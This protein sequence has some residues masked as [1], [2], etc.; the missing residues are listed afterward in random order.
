MSPLAPVVPLPLAVLPAREVFDVTGPLPT[1]TTVLE[2]SAGTGKTYTIAALAVRFVAEG[3]ATLPELMLVTFGREATRELRDRVRERFVEVADGLADPAAARARDDRVLALLA[4]GPDA[5]VIVRRRRLTHA[6]AHFDA[7]TIATTHQ[8]CSRML[9]GLGIVGD[10]DPG[11]EFTEDVD[12]LVT[13]VVDDFYVRKYAD[14]RA[15]RPDFGRAEALAI[16]RR[17]VGDPEARLTPEPGARP[18]TGGEGTA[19]VRRAFAAAVRAE[20]EHRKRARRLYTYD[21]MLTRL[22][23][24]LRHPT[25]GAAACARLRARYRVVLVDEFQDTDPL[26]WAI[27]RAAFH[28]DTSSGTCSLTFIGDPKQAIYAFRGADVVS[29][30]DAADH[31]GTH[32]TLDVNWRSD[33]RLVEALD[34]LLGGAALGDEKIVVGSVRARHQDARLAGAPVDA[35]LRLRVVPRAGLPATER[36]LP[37][38]DGVRARVA[39]DLAADVAALLTSGATWDGAALS[40]GHVAVLVRTNAQGT[41]VHEALGAAGVP[42][43]LG[44]TASVFATPS[45]DEWLVLLEALEQPHRSG[46]VRAAALTCFLGRRAVELDTDGDRLLDEYGGLLRR[47]AVV[48][49]ERGVAALL[50]VVSARTGLAE[51][52]LAASDG[53]RRLTD[54]RHIG[55]ALHAAATSSHLGLV[56]LAEWLRR[57]IAEAGREQRPERSRR[58]ESDADAVQILT[59]HRGKGL[60]FPVVHVPFG[61]DRNVGDPELALHHDEQ[62]RRVLAVGGEADPDWSAHV[63]AH[64]REEAGEDLRLLYVALTR[65]QSQVV[66]WWAPS[67]TTRC[68]PLH[69]LLFGRPEA[70]W[71]GTEPRSGYRVPNDE[72]ALAHLRAVAGPPGSPVVVEAVD[73]NVH[74]AAY[75]PGRDAGAALAAARFT[76]TLDLAWRRT[77]YSALT[78]AAHGAPAGGPA[79][80]SEPEVATTDDEADVDPPAVDPGATAVDDTLALVP[81]PMADLPVGTGFGTL[82]HAVLETVDPTATD[83][84][85][86]LT[87]RAADTLHRRPSAGLEPA[88]LASALV[89]VLSTPLGPEPDAWRLRDVA[90]TDRLAEMDFELPLAGGDTPGATVSL[91]DVEVLL[92]R[93]LGPT[94]PLRTYPDAL[95]GIAAQPLRGYLTGSVDAVLRDAGG[96]YVVVDYK[97]NWLGPVGPAGA[98]PL[99]AAHYRPD[100]LRAAMIAAH[101]P[102]QALLYSV[103]LHRFLR[104]RLRGYDPERHL[105]GS[106]YLFLRGMCGPDTPVADGGRCGVFAWRPPAALVSELSDVLDRGVA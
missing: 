95:A 79:V 81:S 42:A 29:Y 61:W 4:S 5:E 6:L 8:F 35:P 27:L 34:S 18:D 37:R 20:L 23:A 55:Q 26:Q 9:D 85:A 16:G 45:A 10:T 78:A 2:A 3:H 24:A 69:R 47:W 48:L 50:E 83:L 13:E 67:T 32:A 21:D 104:W 106:L 60:E 53:E 88:S 71:V 19:A 99:T 43:V 76:R 66:A 80:G 68:S 65:A 40:P 94:D 39:A 97:T 84:L 82:V 70:G 96:R 75:T 25:L 54:V 98:E 52:M 58:L 36:G 1:G 11:A 86:E 46:R 72:D 89:P 77:S 22:D 102:L 73:P 62:G 91:G 15:R 28:G 59:V 64:Q 33:A 38:V 49:R 14:P 41:L 56:A 100:A 51:R 93:H 101:Y 90:P 92:R 103:A 44:G 12:D 87:G 105:G 74:P 17:A 31:A 57:R 30:L 7:A 63:E